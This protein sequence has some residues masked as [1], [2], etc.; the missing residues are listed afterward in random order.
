MPIKKQTAALVAASLLLIPVIASPA[1]AQSQAEKAKQANAAMDNYQAAANR[2][3]PAISNA[4]KAVQLATKIYDISVKVD[5]AKGTIAQ[6][7][8]KVIDFKN[9]DAIAK[10]NMRCDSPLTVM[11]A[12]AAKLQIDIS[13]FLHTRQK[14][15][16]LAVYAAKLQQMYDH[17]QEIKTD[18]LQLV[19][20]YK[21]E[22]KSFPMGKHRTFQSWV[23]VRY[24]VDTKTIQYGAWFQ[25]SDENKM[26]LIPPPN[27]GLNSNDA[28]KGICIPFVRHAKFCFKVK[29]ATPTSATIDLWCKVHAYG[30]DK[31][32]GF[33][34]VVIPAPFGYLDQL[35]QMKEK[36]KQ[37]AVD[38]VKK[39]LV[40]LINI[41]AETQQKIQTLAGLAAKINE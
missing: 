26:Q 11:K 27:L 7:K 30:E 32:I 35:T 22:K 10:I 40:N 5:K 41:D 16:Q 36:A 4:G 3:G 15:C 31:D 8:E 24:M 28:K 1:L 38:E 14:V 18:G 25:F 34:A 9:A 12:A 6:A 39:R 2:E 17:Y 20:K 13:K 29:S 23:D 21:K 33:G 19:D 37:N